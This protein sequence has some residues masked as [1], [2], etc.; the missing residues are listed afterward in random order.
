MHYYRLLF[1]IIF[2]WVILF[3]VPTYLASF[4]IKLGRLFTKVIIDKN[5]EKNSGILGI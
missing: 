2:C 1:R 4:Y 3:R 5:A